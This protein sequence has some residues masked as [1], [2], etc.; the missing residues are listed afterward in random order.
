MGQLNTAANRIENY[1]PGRAVDSILCSPEASS[2]F[3]LLQEDYSVCNS[4]CFKEETGS[5]NWEK[6]DRAHETLI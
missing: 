5:Q 4:N 6:I 2:H 1:A 3:M